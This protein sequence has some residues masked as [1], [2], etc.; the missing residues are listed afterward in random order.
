MMKYITLLVALSFLSGCLDPK[1][2]HVRPSFLHAQ[3]KDTVDSSEKIPGMLTRNERDEL[4]FSSA[5]ETEAEIETLTVTEQTVIPVSSLKK[6][7]DSYL[8]VPYKLNGQTRSGM[9][10]SGFV[11]RVF[12]DMGHTDF[13][14]TSSAALCK[15]GTRVLLRNVQPGDLI[16][17]RRFARI[18][19]VAIFVE[20]NTFAHASSGA[21][22]SYS[23][24][25]NGF[26]KKHFYCV[27]R[28]YQ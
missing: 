27:R 20:E 21:G 4:D 14:R 25:N 24:F 28:I 13:P 19:H 12:T 18:N 17:F 26:F 5:F 7:I 3:Q 11:W 9:D 6:T 23:N 22:V 10:C 2:L 1:T 8:R 15:M 16:F